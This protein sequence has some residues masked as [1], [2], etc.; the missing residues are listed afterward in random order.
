[1]V[2]FCDFITEAKGIR[3]YSMAIMEVKTWESKGEMYG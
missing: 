1:M 3:C 2:P